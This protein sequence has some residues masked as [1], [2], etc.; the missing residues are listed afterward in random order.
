M[1]GRNPVI[2][3]R[4]II[5]A[6]GCG[7]AQVW[8]AIRGE[9]VGLG[10]LSLFSSPRFA[11]HAVG[12]VRAD[13][14]GLAG[15]LRG[16]RSD[17]LGW[18][19]ARE[20]LI[21]AGLSTPIQ[22]VRAERVGVVMGATV[23]GMLGTEAVLAG[24]LKGRRKRWAPLRHHECSGTAEVC[25][26]LSGALGPCLTLSTAC[27]AGAMAIVTG[28][29]LIENGDV[30]L[31]MVGAAD[32]LSRLTLNGFGSLLLLDPDGCRPFDHRRA[33]ISLGEGAAVLILE[34]AETAWARGARIL[35]KLEGW[36]ASCD[37]HHATAPHPEGLGAA[38]ALR[39]AVDGI[40]GAEPIDFISAHGTGTRDNDAM[41]ARAL[42][43]VLGETLPPVASVKR[44]FG[45]TLAASGAIKAVLCV[46]S[47]IR[48]ATPGNPG[49]QV[50][51]P[52]LNLEPA[53]SFEPRAITR[54]LSNSFGFGGNN[55]ALVF[56]K[57]GPPTDPG[58][59][60][61]G[62]ST[63]P[64]RQPMAILAL[65]VIS[66]V[67]HGMDAVWGALGGGGASSTE[68]EV[69]LLSP[70]MRVPALA[71]GEIDAGCFPDPT[72]R[73]RWS[74]IQ[75][76]I[77]AATYQVA[78]PEFRR[79]WTPERTS[80]SVGT[81]LGALNDTMAFVENLIAND[82]RAPRPT[83]FT[84]SVHNSLA[85]QVAIELGI[86]G[87]NVTTVQREVSFEAALGHGIRRLARCGNDVALV[88]A[89]DELSPHALA[90]GARWGWWDKATSA[91]RARNGLGLRPPWGGRMPAGEGAV[92]VAL[93]SPSPGAARLASVEG[94]RLGR[95]P[96]KSG[97]RLDAEAEARWVEEALESAEIAPGDVDLWLTGANG[98]DPM[99]SAY[100]SVH[101]AW[102]R[103]VGRS[104]PKGRYKQG[105]GEFHTASGFGF[106]VATGLVAGRVDPACCVAGDAWESG[107][108]CRTVVLHTMSSWG[109][110]G[111][112]CL[113]T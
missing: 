33:G 112:T 54:V 52:E 111:V 89:A 31:V 53:R 91:P 108:P 92:M 70:P 100:A 66:P 18:V 23:G 26:T 75:Q 84:N 58:K 97:E 76:M 48:Q 74:R 25:A 113:R 56:S 98:W 24:W 22:G 32:S 49:F 102:T 43:R 107:R 29:E 19:A 110:K 39:G 41:E 5:T 8:E 15:G 13:V 64:R 72:R 77:L 69:P 14:A 109:C 35:A 78:T 62:V 68:I 1:S 42:H 59:M 45:H 94:L 46:Q 12:E 105:C 17:Q 40:H 47:L 79:S 11:A 10:R 88:G 16:S 20:A 104:T 95:M 81:G 57:A 87:P 37:A 6:A 55:V 71:C 86:M 3:G 44:F 101:E 61:S 36:S 90:V 60:T 63:K 4:G 103:R 80:L 50:A 73:R 67:G 51:D 85:S 34:A 83:F 38:R 65:G 82:E 9:H 99:D 93:A 2:T 28:A 7:I 30:D 27:S 106:M 21:D 96:W